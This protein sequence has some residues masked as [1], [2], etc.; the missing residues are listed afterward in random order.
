MTCLPYVALLG[1]NPETIAK[2]AKIVTSWKA[3]IATVISLKVETKLE[4]KYRDEGVRVF[5]NCLHCP[6]Y[7]QLQ[8]SNG[9]RK[10]FIVHYYHLRSSAMRT[11]LKVFRESKVPKLGEN[12][13]IYIRYLGNFR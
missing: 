4:G 1:E 9:I 10:L 12:C 11:L 8:V 13:E 2:M 7:R 5:Q 3:D 6:A